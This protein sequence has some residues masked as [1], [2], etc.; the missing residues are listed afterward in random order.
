MTLRELERRLEEEPG[1][2]SL[3]GQ[4]ADALRQAGRQAEAVDQYRS[5]AI[6]YRDQRQAQQAIAACRSALELAPDDARCRALLGELGAAASGPPGPPE[7][8]EP[9]EPAEIDGKRRRR[10]STWSEDTPL[11]AALPHHIADPTS[12]L[13][14]ISEGELPTTEDAPTRPGTED[15]ALPEV[16][17]IANAARRISATLIGVAAQAAA[18]RTSVEPAPRRPSRYA[19]DEDGAVTAAGGT[20]N[21]YDYGDEEEDDQTQPRDVPMGIHRPGLVPRSPLSEPP[22]LL[23]DVGSTTRSALAFAFFA[24]LPVE[25]RAAVL[26]RFSRRSVPPGTVVIRQGEISPSLVV[27]ASGRLEVRADHGGGPIGL[28]AIGPGEHIGEAPLLSRTPSRASVVSATE[29][30]LLLLAPRDFYEI[31]GAF[32]ALWA[33]LKESAERRTR[34]LDGRR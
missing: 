7:P 22:A 15:G 27:V 23:G 16:S 26:S 21:D 9:P 5:I 2:L 33:A 6:A 34:E 4:V 29:A 25:R 3:R 28:G 19:H 17:G 32:P 31:A 14:R 24:P 12:R 8:P 20:G 10:P 1:N 18:M 11:P 13:R 30:E